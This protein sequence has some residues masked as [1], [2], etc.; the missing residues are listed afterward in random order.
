[1]ARIIY[2]IL[3]VPFVLFVAKNLAFAACRFGFGFE[4]DG[5]F[6]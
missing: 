6:S 5:E 1:M 4:L 3:F 2:F